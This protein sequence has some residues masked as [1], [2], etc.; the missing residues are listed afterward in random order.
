[1]LYSEAYFQ[2]IPE[3]CLYNVS[4]LRVYKDVSI[5]WETNWHIHKREKNEK[6]QAQLSFYR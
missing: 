4:F 3:I 2:N 6:N 5:L 1:M